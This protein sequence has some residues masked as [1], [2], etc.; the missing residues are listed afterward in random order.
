MR[1]SDFGA[2]QIDARAHLSLLFSLAENL[3]DSRVKR[4][5]GRYPF[6]HPGRGE[7]PNEKLSYPTETVLS[8]E[9]R[10]RI[11]PSF[12]DSPRKPFGRRPKVSHTEASV[13]PLSI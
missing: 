13:T 7:R 6:S 11:V 12:K 3:I 10:N 2:E 9:N 5:V 1:E 4:S 8:N